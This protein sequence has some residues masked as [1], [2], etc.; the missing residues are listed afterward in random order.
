MSG[1]TEQM[2]SQ[3]HLWIVVREHDGSGQRSTTGRLPFELNGT[4]EREADGL[5]PEAERL[6][7]LF[8]APAPNTDDLKGETERDGVPEQKFESVEGSGVL[9]TWV[10]TTSQDY[11]EQCWFKFGGVEI[12]K[13]RSEM[14]MSKQDAWKNRDFIILGGSTVAEFVLDAFLALTRSWLP[15]TMCLTVCTLISARCSG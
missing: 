11:F 6:E 4:S 10:S 5:T 9:V 8:L 15:R 1:A 7:K 3:E 13:T 14:G 12:C 2:F